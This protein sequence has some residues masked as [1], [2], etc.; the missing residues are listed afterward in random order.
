MKRQLFFILLLFGLSQSVGATDWYPFIIRNGEKIENY[1]NNSGVTAT[2]VVAG[3]Y[4]Y[5][6]DISDPGGQGNIQSGDYVHFSSA[7]NYILNFS[8]PPTGSTKSVVFYVY[9]LGQGERLTVNGAKVDN[10]FG[11]T[12]TT[13]S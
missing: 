12:G 8:T 7:G 2:S 5:K 9:G 1:K 6:Y 11:G 10:L 4:E 13:S 3:V